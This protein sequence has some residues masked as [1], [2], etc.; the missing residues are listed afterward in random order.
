MQLPAE[1]V[2]TVIGFAVIAN[3]FIEM[4]IKPIFEKFNL[5]KFWLTYI[6]WA[7]AGVLVWL[8]GA[9]LFSASIANQTIGQILTALVA[10]GGS[11]ILYDLTDR[12]SK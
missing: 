6:A 7:A 12:P 9:N 8:T 4:L 5:D 10:G 3:R 11:N 2:V 1:I